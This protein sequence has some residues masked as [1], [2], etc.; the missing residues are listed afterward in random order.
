[1]DKWLVLLNVCLGQF[2][3]AIDARIISVSI[4]TIAVD[5]KADLLSIQ[6]VMLANQLT[7][8]SLLLSFG[9]LG[10]MMGRRSIYTLGFVIFTLGSALCGLCS[11]IG[12]LIFFRIFQAI[13][14]SMIT[15]NGLAILASTF[16]AGERGKALG[17]GSMS[18]HVG[19]LTGPSLGGILLDTVGWRWTFYLTVPIGIAAAAMSRLVLKESRAASAPKGFDLPGVSLLLIT[20]SSFLIALNQGVSYGWTSNFI[21]T[22]FAISGISLILFLLVEKK[23]EN[24]ALDLELFRIKIFSTS[25]ISFFLLTLS[26][27]TLTFL[28]PFYLQGVLA[29][30]PSYVGFILVANSVATVLFAPIGGGLSDKLGSRSLCMAGSILI[31][32]TQFLV[33]GLDEKS[34]V[35]EIVFLLF[36][37]GLGWGFFNSPNHNAILS[38]IPQERVGVAS[39][40]TATVGHV[41]RLA[42]VAFGGAL[43][44]SY[45]HGAKL[46][47]N[48]DYS[49]WATNPHPF[50]YAFQHT[51][52][53]SAL[54]TTIAIFTSA[55][56]HSYKD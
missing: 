17:F 48:M 54:I 22:L 27:G 10:D 8:A 24:P 43:F 40:M 30:K 45:L 37:S 29:Y 50:V 25:E 55:L 14:A 11:N 34:T 53:L 35:A 41:G 12:Q 49:L 6:W 15:A 26:Q 39:G 13:G 9:R 7:M 44:T 56:R 23:A 28:M 19:F 52:L 5:L 3:A 32:L 20:L 47:K 31:C 21:L 16:P 4:P 46:S 2:M 33:C 51:Y 38:S 1:M 36:L 18:F 42:G